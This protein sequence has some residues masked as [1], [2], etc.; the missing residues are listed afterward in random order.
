MHYI[1]GSKLQYCKELYKSP[2]DLL[3]NIICGLGSGYSLGVNKYLNGIKDD[4]AYS[5]P[6]P[7][8]L[9]SMPPFYDA[10]YPL[11]FKGCR[12]PGFK[13]AI[14]YLID[15]INLSDSSNKY[16]K[17]W[18]DNIAILEELRDFEVIADPYENME[19]AIKQFEEDLAASEE[20]KDN[21]ESVTKE[22]VFEVT[23]TDTP[24]F[25]KQEINQ[26]WTDRNL[27]N[28]HYIYIAHLDEDLFESYPRVYL[29]LKHKGVLRNEKAYI[30]LW[31]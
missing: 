14:Q 4:V 9:V 7:K 21:V 16:I 19:T 15:C 22:W 5:F 12:N 20:P 3:T 8:P 17:A 30:R 25:I 2:S 1:I 27:G 23:W 18:K 11:S 28:D 13:E 31:W 6:D 26:I 29:W 24:D 10:R